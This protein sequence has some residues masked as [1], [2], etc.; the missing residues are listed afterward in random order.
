MELYGA[1][2]QNQVPTPRILLRPKLAGPGLDYF[3]MN[4]ID[5]ASFTCLGSPKSRGLRHFRYLTGKTFAFQC[6]NMQELNLQP[7]PYNGIALPI[8]LTLLV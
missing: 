4:M 2:P 5:L 3:P 6:F 7:I 8:E 1:P